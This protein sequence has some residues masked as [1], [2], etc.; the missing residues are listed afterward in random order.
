MGRLSH[1]CL[2][3][4]DGILVFKCLRRLAPD[5]L[6]EKFKTNSDFHS[7]DKR[8]KNKIDIPG[9]RT[10]AGQRSFHSPAVSLWNF[11]PERL[12]KITNISAFKKKLN[13]RSLKSSQ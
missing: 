3:T 6:A 2:S 8:N 5:Y 9:D 7:R 13:T 11:L 4:R 12:T 1:P 10:A